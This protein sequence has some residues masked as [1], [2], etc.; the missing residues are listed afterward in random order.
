MN[1]RNLDKI[2]LDVIGRKL[3]EH[4]RISEGDIDKI[5]ANP[6]LFT[7]VQKRIAANNGQLRLANGLLPFFRRY[8]SVFA[9]VAVMVIAVIAA[10]DLLTTKKE[11]LAEIVVSVSAAMPEAARPNLIPP[12]RKGS[13]LTAGRA[14]NLEMTN[15]VNVER[16]SVKQTVKPQPPKTRVEAEGEFY[17]VSSAG[18][19]EE[20]AGDSR[21]IRVDMPRASLFAMG[22]NVSLEN[23]SET[24][25]ADLLVGSDGITRAI[26]V[27]K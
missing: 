7:L 22:V 25:K 2:T 26:R 23:D 9:G 5:I 8:V 3:I 21:I 14:S 13:D 10:T 11:S 1:N 16:V 12:L 20:T 19:L 17:A 24:V 15:Q 27:V 6:D 18:D 4:S